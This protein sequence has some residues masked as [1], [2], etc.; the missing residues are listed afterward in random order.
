MNPGKYIVPTGCNLNLHINQLHLDPDI[1]PNPKQFDPDRF[2]PENTSNRHPYAYVPFSA[3]PR[4]CIG[5]KYAQL[6]AK[7]VLTEILRRWRVK[8]RDTHETIK[9]FTALILRPLEG[10]FLKFEDRKK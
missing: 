3:G 10:M 7:I 5:Q 1:W 6:E 4:N 2:L 8:S 9:S